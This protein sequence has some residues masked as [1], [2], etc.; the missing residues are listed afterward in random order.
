MTTFNRFYFYAG[1]SAAATGAHEELT[2]TYAHSAEAETADAIIV[3]GGDGTML[4][5]LHKHIGT[6]KPIYGMNCGSVGFLMNPYDVKNLP[7]R[8]QAAHTIALHPLRMQATDKDGATHEAV[9]FNEVAVFRQSRQSAHIKLTV[10]GITR[11]DEMVGDGV[12]VATPA[13]STAY[14]LSARGPIIPLGSN[15]LG[16]TPISPFRPRAWRGALLP[17]GAII[18]LTNLDPDKRPVSVTADFTEVRDMVQVT[19]AADAAR[20]VGVL[21]N[22]DHNLEERIFNEQFVN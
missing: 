12:L 4:E 1:T 21:F 11:M 10:N 22:P 6:G 14:N 2:H 9:A 5:A 20:S 8:L 3:L 15:V 16:L 17:E 7:A 19:I 13:G 18:T